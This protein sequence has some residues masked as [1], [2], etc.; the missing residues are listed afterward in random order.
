MCPRT[1]GLKPSRVYNRITQRYHTQ[2]E[3][4]MKWNLTGHRVSST[5]LGINHINGVV[6]G[7]RIAFDGM[8]WHTIQLDRARKFQG[9]RRVR[10]EVSQAEITQVGVKIDRNRR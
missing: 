1:V 2:T 10:V 6:V 8:V 3:N 9:R 5:Y 4:S 7:S